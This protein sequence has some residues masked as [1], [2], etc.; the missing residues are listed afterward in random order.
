MSTVVQTVAGAAE[1][2][3]TAG[4]GFEDFDP[5][6]QYPETFRAVIKSVSFFTTVAVTTLVIQI[7][8]AGGA[9]ATALQQ[10]VSE[11][12]ITDKFF[13][14]GQDGLV[15]PRNAGAGPSFE[16][17]CVTTGKTVE[18]TFIVDFEIEEIIGGV[19]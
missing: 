16:I 13:S 19:S 1:F 12:S 3:G 11:S 14:C 4:A 2:T 9:P 6:S 17:F 7:R 15:V 8:I 10:L 18:G 5:A